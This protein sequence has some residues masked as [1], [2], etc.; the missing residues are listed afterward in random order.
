MKDSTKWHK[1]KSLSNSEGMSHKPLHTKQRI[2]HQ[3][4]RIYQGRK[5]TGDALSEL[6]KERYEERAFDK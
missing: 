3:L 1:N 5:I 4:Q 2:V 6:F